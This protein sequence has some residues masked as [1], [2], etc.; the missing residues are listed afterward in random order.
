MQGIP[1][2]GKGSFRNILKDLNGRLSSLE[3]GSVEADYVEN[4]DGERLYWGST[5]PT[6]A[7]EGSIW[8]DSSGS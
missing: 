6:D 3:D 7:P 8:I 4:S 5:E 1:E 2:W